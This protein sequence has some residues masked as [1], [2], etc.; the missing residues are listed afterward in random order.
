MNKFTTF[1]TVASLAVASMALSTKANAGA[2]LDRVLAT[3]TLTAAVGTDWE[4]ESFVNDK[5]ELDGADIDVVKGIAK[6]LGV[7]PKFVSPSWDLIVAG[8]WGARFDIGMGGMTPTKAR[9]EKF[10]F[11]AIFMY[12]RSVVVVHKD[13]KAEKLS[14]LDGKIIGASVNSTDEYYV[15]QTLKPEW[16]NPKPIEFKL[17]PGEV[18]TYESY[19]DGLADLALGDGVRL[20]AFIMSDVAAKNAIKVGKPV[21]QIGSTLYSAPGAIAVL[22]GD[23]EFD[24]KIA[25][26][27]KSMKDDGTLSKVMTKWYGVDAS[28]E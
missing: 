17:T 24:E 16:P 28:A 10:S 6:Y 26:A 23:K 12:S 7:E 3:K 9:A 15:R 19:A 11:P 25:A 8:N 21:K 27:I 2:V 14:D 4:M 1:A 18:K 13:S 5:G 22:R 20:N